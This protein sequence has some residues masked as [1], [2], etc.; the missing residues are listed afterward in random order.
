MKQKK[1]MEA[2]KKRQKDYDDML[3]RPGKSSRVNSS[4]YHRP[5]AV[6]G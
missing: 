1:R 3:S 2:L 6:R 5:G 4:S